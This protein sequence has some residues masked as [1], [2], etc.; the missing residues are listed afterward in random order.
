MYKKRIDKKYR[1]LNLLKSM[2]VVGSVPSAQTYDADTEGHLPDYTLVNLVLQPHVSVNDPN[3]II[4]NGEITSQLTNIVWTGKI[5]IGDTVSNEAITSPNYFVYAAVGS[6]E[7]GRITIKRNFAA[8]VHLMLMFE[9]DYIDSRPQPSQVQHVTMEYEVVCRNATSAPPTLDIDSPETF[10]WNPWRDNPIHAVTACLRRAKEVIS[11]VTYYWEKKRSNGEWTAIG[12][13]TYDDLE[14]SLSANGDTFTQDMRAMGERLDMRVRATYPSKPTL[15][16]DSPA[17]YFT[18]IRRLPNF[19][20]EFGGV[21]HNIEP[22]VDTI[23]PKLM[24]DDHHGKVTNPAGTPTQLGEVR[25]AWM[26]APGVASGSLTYEEVAW[27]GE[28]AI[29]TDKI[30]AN[31]MVL[32]VEV[33]DRGA[34]KIVVGLTGKVVVGLG[35]NP[36]VV[37]NR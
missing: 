32:G 9:A 30:N 31:G 10:V 12:S 2:E 5:V 21:P 3:G 13:E 24:V 8:D 1:P 6:E 35:E 14:Y 27:G 4:E 15:A 37:M 11:N 25:A 16:A 28:P 34:K 17:K 19:E 26:T 22:D 7:N 29:P 18:L 33:K 20:Y 36:N 23:Y